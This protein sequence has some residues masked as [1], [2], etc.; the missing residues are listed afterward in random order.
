VSDTGHGKRRVTSLWEQLQPSLSNSTPLLGIQSRPI[1]RAIRRGVAAWL[2]LF[3]S[4][5]V[6]QRTQFIV[7]SSWK[8]TATSCQLVRNMPCCMD[9]E[10]LSPYSFHI[11]T[12]PNSEPVKS[13]T[14]KPILNVYV[15]LEVQLYVRV[16][17]P[18]PAPM[19]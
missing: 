11:V 8:T 1:A 3:G 4:H 5:M 16:S 7:F 19:D 2:G 12:E 9:P 15:R 14:S 18:V 13:T 17:Q 6:V 10:G